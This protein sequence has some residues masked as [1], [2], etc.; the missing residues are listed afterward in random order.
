MEPIYQELPFPPGSFVDFYKEELPHFVVPWHNHTRIEIMH[1]ITGSGI[2]FVGDHVERYEPGDTCIIGPRLPHEWRSG[3]EHFIA[4]KSVMASCY[5][6]F[7][8]KEIFET[9]FIRL[10]EME[11]IRLLLERSLRGIKF[12][13]D[14]RDKIG[15]FIKE[16]IQAK[17]SA[18]IINLIALLDLMSTTDEYELLAGLGYTKN[19]KSDDF[20]RFNKIYQYTINNFSRPISLSEISSY[21]GLTPTA[22]CRYFTKRTKRT[23]IQYLNE[24][25]IG[26]A[27]KLLIEGNLKISTVCMES[28][29]NN[30]SHFI[31][32]FRRSTQLSPSEYQKIFG[33]KNRKVL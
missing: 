31:D 3:E 12:V 24:I 16:I 2:R 29:F 22:F 6:I 1:I 8:E 30:L 32:L 18:K 28:G 33:V 10:P 21:V 11:N 17:G 15:A 23:F 4:G 14:S 7:F 20:D 5:C 26:H 13:G 19:K 27:K 25:R 9:N